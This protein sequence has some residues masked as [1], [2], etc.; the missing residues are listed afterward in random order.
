MTSES[1]RS[2]NTH[3]I[4]PTAPARGPDVIAGV[5]AEPDAPVPEPVA[6]ARAVDAPLPVGHEVTAAGSPS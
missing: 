2:Q 5:A 1:E 4:A 3:E 6:L